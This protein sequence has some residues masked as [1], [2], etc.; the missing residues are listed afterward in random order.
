M[1]INELKHLYMGGG[2]VWDQHILYITYK[3]PQRTTNQSHFQ[4]TLPAEVTQTSDLDAFFSAFESF[5][6]SFQFT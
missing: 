1:A 3:Y 4:T 2:R 6:F 5:V